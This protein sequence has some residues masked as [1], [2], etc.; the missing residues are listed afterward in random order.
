MTA[1]ARHHSEWLSL[2]ES[3]GPFLSLPVLADV[4]PQGL[5]AHD[6]AHIALLR[7]AAREWGENRTPDPAIH[8]AWIR[9]VLS[10]TLGFPDQLIAE[11]QALPAQL[12]VPVLEYGETLRPDLAI[13]TPPGRAEAG[14]P[15]LLVQ[16]LP[17]GQA[18]EKALPGRRWSASPATRM[19]D[20]LHGSGVRLGLV[21]NGE[22]WVLVNAPPRETSGFASWFTPLWL[23]EPLTLQAF[24][25]LLSMHRFFGVADPETPE[26]LL[27]RSAADQQEVTDQLGRQV[28]DAVE[29]LIQA[30]DRIDKD[31]G[32]ALLRDV[33]ETRLYESA[34]T[35][36]MRLVFLLAAEERDLL[37]GKE[38][39]REIYDTSYAASTLRAQLRAAA[40]RAGEEILERRYDAWSR[41]IAAF[42]AVYGGVRHERLELAAY[43]G[44]LFDPDRFPFLEGRPAGTSW[45]ETQ[46]LP[47]P[48]NNR[49]V[50]HLLEA[51]QQLQ[52]RV[53]GGVE[54]RLLSFRSLDIEQIGH[55]YE[56]LLDHTARRT[57]EPMLGL[58]GS[59]DR[60]P[61][62]SLAA[63]EA[64]AAQSSAPLLTYLKEETGRSENALRKILPVEN[65][66]G[67]LLAGHSP[68][69]LTACDNDE[70]L[71]RRVLPFA[72]LLRADSNGYPVVITTGSVY[73]TKGND[74]RSTG[75][76]YT[77]RS[78]TEPIV[79]YTL[80]PLVYHGPAEGLPKEEWRLRTPAEL[81]GL[82]IC[83]MAM[84]SG[85]FLVQTCR[86]LSERLVEAWEA[87]EAAQPGRVVISPEGALSSGDP[88]ERPIPREAEER[89]A[90]ARRLVAD[91]CLY[92]VDK[93]PMAVEMAKLSLWLITLQKD[94]PFTFLDHALRCGDSLLG[95]DTEKLQAWSLGYSHL[96]QY[97]IFEESIRRA[98]ERS[99][100][101]RRR[102]L[103][104]AERDIH[105]IQE[106]TRLLQE[107][108]K[109]TELMRLGADLLLST[110]LVNKRQQEAVRVDLLAR[111]SIVLAAAE[112]QI[113]HPYT[114]LG[115][116]QATEA[117]LL[118]QEEAVNR[119]GGHGPFHWML[120]FPEV[121]FDL[122]T[123]VASEGFSAFVGNP[124]FVGGQRITGTLSENYRDY[125]V[126]YLAGGRRGSA[127]L[128][129][130]FFL[131]ASKQ[132]RKYGG[133]GL[134]ATNT[135]AQ[136]DT[137]EVGLDQILADG[138]VV[139]RAVASRP[140]PGSANLEVAQVWARRGPW[141][142]PFILNDQEV[143]G[144]TA[145]LTA[146]GAVTGTPF[147]L[148]ANEGRSFQGSIVLGMGFVLEPEEAE[149]L[150]D[151]DPRNREVLFPY[152]G[153]EDLNSRPDQSPSR[154]VINFHDWP[155][156]RA[157]RY[158]EVMAIVR[159][160]VKPERDRNTFSKTAKEKWW[161]YERGRQELYAT[162]AGMQ[163]VLIHGFTSKY[164][165]FGFAPNGYIYAGPHN[166]F[167]LSQYADL[168]LLQCGFHQIWVGEYA[169]THETRI[170]YANHRQSIM[171]ARQEGL[172]K[173]YNRFHTPA[174]HSDDIATLRD[175]HVE[176]DQAVA[177]AYGW[178]DLDLGYGFH[179]TKQGV[180]YTISEAARREVLGRLLALNHARYAEEVRQGL[181]DKGA[182]GKGS[183]KGRRGTR[184][185]VGQAALFGE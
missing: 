107:S 122:D 165:L 126:D 91:R 154:W 123:F 7:Q 149:A 66:Q 75:T 170:R 132:V 73:V 119:L 6:A 43:G 135:I 77:P 115:R 166:V 4:F 34:L 60:E 70:A 85:A 177:A 146:P 90:L 129:A 127:D 172:T 35:V 15:R 160:K 147:R 33:D 20:L 13:L 64:K 30:L 178:T 88:S 134:I 164:V 181:H 31:S 57:T 140:W 105:D 5:E 143:S 12:A 36:M 10:E 1:I 40:D 97:S 109:A 167:A 38:T 52:V 41:L 101:L 56:G 162:I 2:V 84:G 55:V 180:R 96:H 176:M 28:R 161:Q 67:S 184:G 45:R 98:V 53:S 18:L 94:R 87:A 65:G 153:G 71:F 93:N 86:Y 61:E 118:L 69:L 158:P 59:K 110:V 130:Y 125:L 39:D 51:L 151:R 133:F 116:Q 3:S 182:K 95:L 62:L 22:Q 152:L 24:R 124:P 8:R 106:K 29:I 49:T 32:R 21:T 47:L 11:G 17:P 128:C 104:Q 114:A 42:R 185:A 68:H 148:K 89:L 117:L 37:P 108:L 142:K 137:R 23:E 74:R 145:F 14:T 76:H 80:E 81:L 169:S 99:I 46:A 159:E 102:I 155:L 131:R 54:A 171:L 121:F 26:A 103:A 173:T 50:L 48:I 163:R 168:A 141:S 136:G 150:I 72:P 111:Y 175:L 120:E 138:Y 179:Q 113:R 156:E 82:K 183:A 174:E 44:G 19:V 112:E 92:G 79:R 25:T 100:Y 144:I 83:D 27:D 16:I 78:L 157:E 58:A 9:F 139:P 63:L